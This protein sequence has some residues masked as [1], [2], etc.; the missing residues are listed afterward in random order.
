MRNLLQDKTKHYKVFAEDAYNSFRRLRYGIDAGKPDADYQTS[1][2]RKE[3]VDWQSNADNDALTQTSISY[4]GWLPI[5][6]HSSDESVEFSSNVSS[7]PY[8]YLKVCSND[9][10]NV[11]LSYNYGVNQNQNIIDVNTS[12]C[13]TRIN[14]NPAI[15]I[16]NQPSAQFT[17]HQSVASTQWVI[18]HSLGFIP[19]VFIMNEAG[20]EIIGIVDSATT[21]QMTISFTDP[22]TGY[23]Y[24]S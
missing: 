5:T 10:V 11:G 14:L 17:H 2:I 18:N 3:L 22:V 7:D 21:T 12:G 15:T 20:T 13:V 24:L 6:Y 19:N 1:S 4:Y 9:P 8:R 16:N 23:A